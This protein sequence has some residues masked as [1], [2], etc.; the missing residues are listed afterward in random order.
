MGGAKGGA[1]FDPRGKS[2]AEIMRFCQSFM[3]ALYRTSGRTS[4]SRPGTSV[5]VAGNR[6]SVRTVRRIR[7]AFENGVI[8]GKGMA[9][10]G[11]L[12]RPEAT[13]FG[14]VYY[15]NEVFAHENDS[16]WGKTFALSGFGNVTWGLPAKSPNWAER[17]SRFRG[18][19]AI[20][21]TRRAS[22]PEKI[23]Y[24]LEMRNSGRDKVQDY[25]D[26]FE[27]PSIPRK[28]LGRAGRRGVSLRHAKRRPS[29]R[30]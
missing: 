12:I 22:T 7:G 16:L 28:A 21:S 10:G 20:S 13:G 5:W 3:T 6:V 23:D 17:L 4:T 18:R 8:T 11:S 27:V 25:A 30:R 9:F 2:D 1:D 14:A 26:K 29:G 19:T 15:T 24:L